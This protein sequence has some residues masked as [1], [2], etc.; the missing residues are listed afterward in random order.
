MKQ[1]LEEVPRENIPRDVKSIRTMWVW[2]I[3]T[4]QYGY[5]IRF[6]ARIVTPGN[7]QRAGID[8]NETF[9]PVARMESF[10]LVVGLAA[11]LG[12]NL[13]G[14]DINTAYLNAEL[15]ISQYVLNIDEFPCKNP[16]NLYL[17]RKALYGLRQSGRDW[18]EELDFWMIDHGYQ[19]CSTEPSLYHRMKT[20][21]IIVLVLVYVDNILCATNDE[22]E[23]LEFFHL[24][25]YQYGM[26]GQG[27]L[28]EYLSVHVMVKEDSIS[29]D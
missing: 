23:N 24:L 1:V 18:N 13:Y 20:N 15:K 8:F 29:I 16:D 17:V 25:D 22:S 9:S 11:E 12:L 6:K 7:R 14:G 4:D 21:G 5:V 19:R 2:A 10:F 26:K 3:K 27:E 28:T